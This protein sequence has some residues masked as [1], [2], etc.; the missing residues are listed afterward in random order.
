MEIC[1]VAFQRTAFKANKKL[2][3]VCFCERR[4]TGILPGVNL[5][6]GFRV[7]ARDIIL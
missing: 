6:Y 3:N 4:T 5:N 7:V 2:R 1:R